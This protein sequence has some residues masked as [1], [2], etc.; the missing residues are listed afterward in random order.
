MDD[1]RGEGYDDVDEAAA[2]VRGDPSS[3]DEVVRSSGKHTFSEVETGLP[4][5]SSGTPKTA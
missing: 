4:D 2:G 3:R 1:V 5:K